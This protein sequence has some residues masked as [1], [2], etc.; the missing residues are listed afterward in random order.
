MMV[1]PWRLERQT[2]TVSRKSSKLTIYIYLLL[3]YSSYAPWSPF[4]VQTPLVVK[5]RHSY[6]DSTCRQ[7]KLR[8]FI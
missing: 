4:G 6:V 3:T 7:Y 1:G 8:S 5:T 2:S